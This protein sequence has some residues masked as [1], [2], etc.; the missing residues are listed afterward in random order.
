MRFHLKKEA[1]TVRPILLVLYYQTVKNARLL[2]EKFELDQSKRKS[3][4]GTE[5]VLESSGRKR[6]MT[7]DSVWLVLSNTELFCSMKSFSYDTCFARVLF[8]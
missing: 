4:Q 6:V 5:F 1:N 7:C 8:S 2:T 3:L